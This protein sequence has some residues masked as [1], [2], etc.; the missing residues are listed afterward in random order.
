MYKVFFLGKVERIMVFGAG[1]SLN[2]RH[3]LFE[4]IREIY[5]T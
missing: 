2:Y 4:S 3:C 1:N 5:R